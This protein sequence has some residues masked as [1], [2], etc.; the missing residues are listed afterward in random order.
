MTL[1]SATESFMRSNLLDTFSAQ[2]LAAWLDRNAMDDTEREE[3]TIN[4]LRALDEDPSRIDSL[5]WSDM[6]RMGRS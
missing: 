4:I 1:G 2:H 5:S 3:M 6:N